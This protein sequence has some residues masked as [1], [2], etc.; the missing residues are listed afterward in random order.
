MFSRPEQRVARDLASGAEAV[1]IEALALASQ[2]GDEAQMARARE[3]LATSFAH[4]QD[5]DLERAVAR[6]AGVVEGL[7]RSGEAYGLCVALSDQACLLAS[8]DRDEQVQRELVDE[9]TALEEQLG[10]VSQLPL[11]WATQAELAFDD[12]ELE[13]AALLAR[14]T[15]PRAGVACFE[16]LALIDAPPRWNR[17][18]GPRSPGWGE[19][20]GRACASKLATTAPRETRLASGVG[21]LTCGA[22]RQLSGR[23]TPPAARL[24]GSPLFGESLRPRAQTDGVA[25]G[26]VG[27][28]TRRRVSCGLKRCGPE[29]GQAAA[30]RPLPSG[31]PPPKP[32]YPVVISRR[33]FLL[34]R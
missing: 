13:R 14:H 20:F 8:S 22:S 5:D 18:G 34:S 11:L 30:P 16:L 32:P 27:R 17:C 2:R 4:R 31:S 33:R 10:F 23:I 26:R 15:E 25:A 19:P 3:W 7:R 6:H 9:A 21:P 29:S 12:G 24:G 28:A 1:A